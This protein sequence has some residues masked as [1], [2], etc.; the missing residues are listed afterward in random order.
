MKNSNMNPQF[1]IYYFDILA[2][3]NFGFQI[4][5]SHL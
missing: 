1:L 4:L 2:A 5:N 3:F